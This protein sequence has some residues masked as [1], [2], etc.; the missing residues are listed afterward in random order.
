L[1][2]NRSLTNRIVTSMLMLTLAALVTFFF[3]NWVFALLASYLIG[4]G[5]LE[6]FS[7]IENK[8][9][10]VYKYIAIGIGMLIPIII[11]LQHGYEGY[12]GLE[13][14]YIVLACLFI[15]V[16]Q[17]TRKDGS[18]ALVSIAVTLLGLLYIAWFFSFFIKLKFLPNG[19]RLVSF[20]ILV[21]KMGDVG[22]FFIG[23]AIGRHNLIPRISPHKTIEGTI[24]GLVFSLLTAMASKLYL[25]GFH[26][27][28]LLLLGVLL[29]VLAQVGDLAES[30]LKR[31]CAM[32]DSGKHLSG[33]GGVLDLID[34]LIFTVPIF[35]FYVI[36]VIK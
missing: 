10:F 31:D 35:Y 13:P 4:I 5:L 15:F 30:L 24:G 36:V 12:L 7:M 32:K 33:F 14:F 1:A 17:F 34:S 18:Q 16:L 28:H 26:Y 27:A 9:I 8:N 23:N 11:Y 22:A 21:T 29:G 2:D 25:P 6:F 20:V 19:A 3:P